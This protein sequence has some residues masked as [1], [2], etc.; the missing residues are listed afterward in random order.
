MSNNLPSLFTAAEISVKFKGRIS[1]ARLIELCDCKMAPHYEF[2][3]ERY[4]K[5]SEIREWIND[6]LIIQIESR[7]IPRSFPVVK[8]VEQEIED[9]KVPDALALMKQYLVPLPIRSLPHAKFPGVYFLC[10]E[11]EVVYVGQSKEVSGRVGAHMGD[12]EFDF[13][14]CVHVPRSDLDYV[15]GELIR[16]LQPKYNFG[17]D[18]VIRAPYGSKISCTTSVEIAKAAHA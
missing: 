16:R 14:F 9:A 12:K 5:F 1:E 2:E 11:G 13:A 15:E 4:F 8:M 17:S 7:P 10:H 6:N 3:G 18:G